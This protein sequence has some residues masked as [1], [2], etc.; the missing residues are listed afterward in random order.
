LVKSK[1]WNKV[2]HI[3][4]LCFLWFPGQKWL[5][6]NTKLQILII[7]LGRIIRFF[8]I[9][10]EH[11][12]LEWLWIP[13][14]NSKFIFSIL[15]V[16]ISQSNIIINSKISNWIINW[17]FLL[18]LKLFWLNNPIMLFNLLCCFKVVER[19]SDIFILAKVWNEVVNWMWLWKLFLWYNIPFM[20][21]F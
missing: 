2:V 20:L 1:V 8:Y 16:L 5:S 15:H 17:I 11:L 6:L 13:F 9:N 3:V 12:I 7:T 14:F 18:L 21:Q 10:L 19:I 4:S